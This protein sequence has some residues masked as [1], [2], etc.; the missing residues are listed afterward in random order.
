[1]SNRSRGSSPRKMRRFKIAI[2]GTPMENNVMELWSLLSITAP[3]LFPNPARFKEYYVQPIEKKGDAGLLAVPLQGKAGFTL[4]PPSE[5]GVH[6]T[7]VLS[8]AKAAE[9]QIRLNGSGVALGD[10]DGDGLCDIYLCGLENRNG[11]GCLVGCCDFRLVARTCQ[12]L[13]C[14]CA[15]PGGGDVEHLDAANTRSGQSLY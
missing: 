8:D 5:T 1:M 11:R 10:V 2:T 3:G 4:L 14:Q 7:N 9:N 12:Q 13:H 15:E 6:F